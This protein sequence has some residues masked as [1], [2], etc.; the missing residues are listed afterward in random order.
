MIVQKFFLLFAL[1]VLGFPLAKGQ[2]VVRIDPDDRMDVILQKASSVVPSKRQLEW[3]KMEFTLF[4]HF[5]MNTFTN[6]EWGEKGTP[7]STFNPTALDAEQWAITARDAGAT[8]ILMVAKHHDGFCLWPSKY[9]EYSVKNSPWKGGNGDVVAEVSAACRKYGLKFGVY[10]SPWDINSPLYGTD[11]Y[12]TYFKNQL[13][14]LLTQYGEISEV[15]FDGACGE[16]ANGKKQ[17]YD[18]SGYYSVIREL[19]PDAVIAVMGPDVRWVGTES[20][21]GRETE[22]SVVPAT[23]AILDQI[24]NSSQKE[25]LNAAFNP[26]R[27]MMEEDLGSREKI[28][29]ADGLIW[30]PSEVDVSIRDG[31]FYHASQDSTVKSPEKLVDIYYSSVG[32]NSLLLLNVPPDKRGLIHEKDV[33]SLK[34][35]RKM[36]DKTFSKVILADTNPVAIDNI[37]E[38]SLAQPENFDVLLLQEDVTK[39]QRIEKFRLEICKDGQWMEVV[40]GTTIGYKRLL[41][42]DKTRAEKIR[43][44]ILESRAEPAIKTIKIFNSPQ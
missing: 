34:G 44:H 5:G 41:K 14:E 11:E 21:Y 22:W 19:A 31:W 3:Q 4:V 9:T 10:L 39:G 20:G 1:L 15:W 27:D 26:Y 18:W 38:Y 7:A 42:F 8:L 33:A 43:V 29:K 24:A 25:N 35:M 12:N 2:S 40:K 13:K 17:V 32:R 30:Y 36:L 28:V 23:A 6:R 37:F 16:G